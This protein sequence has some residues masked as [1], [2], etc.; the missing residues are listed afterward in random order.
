MN[1][2]QE[3]VLGFIRGR[4]D[5]ICAVSPDLYEEF[6]L[7]DPLRSDQV[8][9]SKAGLRTVVNRLIQAGALQDAGREPDNGSRVVYCPG[10][11]QFEGR[12]L[13]HE[14]PAPADRPQ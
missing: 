7:P 11:H 12:L 14:D 8:L 1:E 2:I 9:L 13:P 4:E 10:A 6:C 5:G 3:K